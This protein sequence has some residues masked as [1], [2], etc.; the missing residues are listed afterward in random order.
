V[1]CYLREDGRVTVR[2]FNAAAERVA[3]FTDTRYAGPQTCTLDMR[4]YANGVYFYKVGMKYGGGRTEDLPLKK[5][6]VRKR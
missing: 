2:V 3:E 4:E 6:T 5:F 1:A